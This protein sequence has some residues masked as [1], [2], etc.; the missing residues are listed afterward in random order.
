MLLKGIFKNHQSRLMDLVGELEELAVG[1][2]LEMKGNKFVPQRKNPLSV[3]QLELLS[4]RKDPRI[5][6]RILDGISVY[7]DDLPLEAREQLV[8]EMVEKLEE[9]KR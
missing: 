7:F 8:E 1:L 2:L 9:D 6:C 4:L 5:N 3:T